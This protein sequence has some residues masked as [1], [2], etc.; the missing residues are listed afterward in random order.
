MKKLKLL[1]SQVQNFLFGQG[2]WRTIG[3]FTGLAFIGAIIYFSFQLW[4]N[5]RTETVVTL[6]E[7]KS[8]K[9]NEDL[10]NS[11]P[12]VGG[13]F[14][15]YQQKLNGLKKFFPGAEWKRSAI[16]LS[17]KEFEQQMAQYDED[18][19]AYI[20]SYYGE[21]EYPEKP[22]KETEIPYSMYTLLEDA[23]KAN[24]IDSLDF[25][26]KIELLDK[27][28]FLV[29]LTNKKGLDTL[30]HRD[31]KNLLEH[32]KNLTL[33][34]L[35]NAVELHYSITKT[36]PVF[37][38]NGKPVLFARKS[39]LIQFWEDGINTDIS[40]EKWEAVKEFAMFTKNS[41]KCKDTLVRLETCSS[42]LSFQLIMDEEGASDQNA[43]LNNIQ[44]LY[45]EG[46]VF[47]LKAE[48]LNQNVSTY[49][50]L[51]K[52]KYNMSLI[53]Q[54]AREILRKENKESG[55][56]WIGITLLFF[57]FCAMIYKLNKLNTSNHEN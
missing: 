10:S 47:N 35:K 52:E 28:E 2:L 32:S 40:Q 22:Q 39:A 27:I 19:K 16:V 46:N 20:N 12:S 9:I 24:K 3:V 57:S 33:D 49:L 4:P 29:G 18:Y 53:D 51:A 54:K 15:D 56:L 48:S 7:F 23:F 41:L 17:D 21:V 1:L 14:D 37:S 11:E 38:N 42:L 25:E 8:G 45:N 43:E 31:F 44:H 55:K 30:F 13:S 36:K 6:N 5:G 34:E 26:H 50:T